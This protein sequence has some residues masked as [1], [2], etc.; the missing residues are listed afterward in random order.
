MKPRS[1][2][3]TADLFFFSVI[4]FQKPARFGLENKNASGTILLVEKAIHQKEKATR[5]L[6]L[7]NKFTVH[8]THLTLRSEKVGGAMSYLFK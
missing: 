8:V 2:K 1:P 5:L 7:E 4:L 3:N 6:L